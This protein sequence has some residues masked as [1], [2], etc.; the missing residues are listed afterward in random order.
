MLRSAGSQTI[1]SV[2]RDEPSGV[3]LDRTRGTVGRTHA[4]QVAVDK[5]DV[6]CLGARREGE[7]LVLLRR[8]DGIDD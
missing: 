6:V 8:E 4:P 2:S 3:D 5:S 1:A 7:V